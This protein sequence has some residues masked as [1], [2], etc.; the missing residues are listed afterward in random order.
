MKLKINQCFLM[1]QFLW[2]CLL[3]LI[4]FTMIHC[5]KA[6]N[7]GMS[8]HFLWSSLTCPFLGLEP[9]ARLPG[10]LTMHG[11][12]TKT[13]TINNYYSFAKNSKHHN[14]NKTSTPS[15]SHSWISQFILEFESKC[16]DNLKWHIQSAECSDGRSH[17]KLTQTVPFINIGFKWVTMLFLCSNASKCNICLVILTTID[18]HAQHAKFPVVHARRVPSMSECARTVCN[19]TLITSKLHVTM[20]VGLD[21]DKEFLHTYLFT[22]TIYIWKF[23]TSDMLTN[24]EKVVSGMEQKPLLSHMHSYMPD[25]VTIPCICEILFEPLRSLP[26]GK[27]LDVIIV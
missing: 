13:I 7:Q 11:V 16:K 18:S 22:Y 24:I 19:E 21:S 15:F 3:F 6:N 27:N 5:P 26:G 17:N 14:G 1:V 4:S 20:K 12:E 9:L 10:A 25:C 23:S 2:S 8:D